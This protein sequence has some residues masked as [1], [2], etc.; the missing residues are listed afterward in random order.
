MFLYYYSRPPHMFE[1]IS[2]L[3][4]T[5]SLTD[6][7]TILLIDKDQVPDLAILCRIPGVTSIHLHIFQHHSHFVGN[8]QLRGAID[9]HFIDK[10][11]IK[12]TNF[13]FIL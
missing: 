9:L 1:N 2:T 11:K 4:T 8:L 7:N 12:L 5:S 6:T 13:R 10:L 3:S